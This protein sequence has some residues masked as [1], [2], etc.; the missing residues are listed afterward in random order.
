MTT[1]EQ[2]GVVMHGPAATHDVVCPVYGCTNSAVLQISASP[3][4]FDPCWECQDK[5]GLRTM[6]LGRFGRWWFG[7]VLKRI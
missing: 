7:D 1:K 5:H 6:K 3:S 4:V 2:A